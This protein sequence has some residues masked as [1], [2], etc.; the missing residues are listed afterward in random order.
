MTTTSTP[1][2]SAQLPN[3]ASCLHAVLQGR[4]LTDA[5]ASLVPADRPAAQALAFHAL[6]HH[7]LSRALV[8][9]LAPR[10]PAPAVQA[11][12]EVAVS[13]LAADDGPRYAAHT[14]VDQTVAAARARRATAGAAGFLNACLRRLLR[15]G[16]A[17]RASLGDDP[18]AQHGHPRWW[19]DRVR[20]DHPDGWAEMLAASRVPAPMTLRVNRRRAARADWQARLRAAEGVDSRAWGEDGVVLD[21]PLPVERLPG[22]AAGEVS[23]QDAAA[24]HAAP[25]LLAGRD[26]GPGDR[27]LDACAAPGGKSAHLL[28]CADIDLLSLDID[29]ARCRRVAETFARLGL[30]GTV[31]CAD[32]ARPDTW[33]DGRPFDAILL[34][35]PCTASG[36]V[37]RHPD[38][39][40]LRREADVA[41]LVTTQRAL[42]DALWPLL[43]PGGRLLYATCSV[44]RA[45]GADQAAAF[46]E[47]HTDARERPCLGHL[48][49]GSGAATDQVNDNPPG[50]YDG[51]F[52]ARFDKAP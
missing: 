10:A 39:P 47:R 21:R 35:A 52:Y 29:D 26:W 34:D 30:P 40:W 44:F 25:L 6:R 12:L 1:P 9:R 27:V 5:L 42:L 7:G 24:Q 33:W 51:F 46:L 13:L 17:L 2:L 28:E 50:G 36:I 15:E 38:V 41:A 20:A 14:V 19:I 45:E 23:V 49:P 8:A 18:V 37:R 43:R 3:A 32:A 4:S 11:L 48:R 31:R 16:D 22:F